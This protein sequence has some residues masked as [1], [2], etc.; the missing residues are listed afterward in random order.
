MEANELGIFGRRFGTE[1]V[2]DKKLERA[3]RFGIVSKQTE[4]AKMKAR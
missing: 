3:L 1:T 4:Q 2:E